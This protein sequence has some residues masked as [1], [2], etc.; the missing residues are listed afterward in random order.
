MWVP[1]RSEMY[2]SRMV[3]IEQY[4]LPIR[5][6]ILSGNAFSDLYVR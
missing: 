2:T 3:V 1:T 5:I 6:P 4:P